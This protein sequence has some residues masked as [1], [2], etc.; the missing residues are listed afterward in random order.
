MAGLDN[1][2]DHS[3]CIADI[4]HLKG[5]DKAQWET[6]SK[7]GD[8]IDAIMTRINVTLGGVTVSVILLAINLIM[9]LAGKKP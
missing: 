6:L 7:Q 4:E 5:T 1:C 3:G 8:R 2:S 9:S